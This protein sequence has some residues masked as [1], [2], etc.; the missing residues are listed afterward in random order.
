[1]SNISSRVSAALRNASA[2]TSAAT[3]HRAAILPAA[4]RAWRVPVESA[5]TIYDGVVQNL[6]D[7]AAA[8][9]E[10]D[11]AR[12][13][14]VA[15]GDSLRRDRDAAEEALRDAL[16]QVRSAVQLGFADHPEVQVAALPGNR[17]DLLHFAHA[18]HAQL[19]LVD[20]RAHL[21]FGSGEL[22]TLALA[23]ALA[24]P[25]EALGTGLER[26]SHEAQQLVAALEARDAAY[27]DFRTV[28]RSTGLVLEGFF[29]AA[30]EARLAEN[31]RPT[32]RRLSGRD[33][34]ADNDE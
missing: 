12:M 17:A 30:G 34:V 1:V 29:R 3:T 27:A 16:R 28:Y 18:V 11:R 13:A 8:F 4:A 10:A 5:A 23:D 19:V 33:A 2:V 24:G 26:V 14:E 15:D 32:E 31:I 9:Q 25:M 21:P 7:A 22:S 20:R 6:V